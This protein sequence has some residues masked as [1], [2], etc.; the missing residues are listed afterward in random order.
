MIE[1]CDIVEGAGPLVVS[2]PHSGKALADGMVERMTSE[3]LRLPDT[4]WHVP[5]LYDFL[6]ELRASVIQANYSRYVV[7]LN[8]DPAGVSLYPGQATTGLV[9]V[10]T[11]AGLPVYLAKEA[12]D[13]R[14]IDSRAKQYFRSYHS[15]LARLLERAV[16]SHGFALLWDA[17]SIASEV[18]RLFEGE[19]PA[20]NLGT[21]SGASCAGEVR[22]AAGRALEGGG[23][24][25]VV[26]GRFRG[27]WITRHYGQP[28]RNVHALQ[29]EIAQSAYMD[30]RDF[31]FDAGKASRLRPVL[32]TVMTEA[33]V[34]TASLY[35]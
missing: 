34:A 29:M 35:S 13:E 6:D 16:E 4:D 17:H 14:E 15:Q 31:S 28:A 33:L 24:A 10:E 22:E 21:N 25:H 26:D 27:G 2:M 8:R 32:K 20:L 18:P 9:P 19:L 23:Y 12:P 5:R 30:E 11:F 1:I 7:D 3:A